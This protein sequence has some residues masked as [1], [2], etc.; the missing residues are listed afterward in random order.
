MCSPLDLF[1]RSQRK[2][3]MRQSFFIVLCACFLVPSTA[4]PVLA[5]NWGH[6]RGVNGNSVA[7][8]ANPPT[9]FGPSKNLKWKVAIPGRGSGSPVVWDQQVFAVTA[10]PGTKGNNSLQFQIHCYDRATGKPLWMKTAIEQVPPD[11]THPTNGYASASPCTDGKHVYAHFGSQGLYCYTMQGELVWER[12]FGTMR[13]RRSFGEGSSPTLVD[14]MI[15]V[16]WDHENGSKLFAVNNKTGELI[17]EVNRDEPTCWATPLIATD[18]SGRKQIVMNGQTAARGYDLKTGK[19]LWQCSGQTQR[20]CASAVA[21]QGIAYVASGFQ[22]SFVGAFDM[23]GAGNLKGTKS[24]KWTHDRNTPDVASPALSDNRL[25]YFKEKSGLLTCVDAASGKEHYSAARIDGVSNTYASP[26]VAGGYV[27]LT[28]RKGTIAVI[29]D[30]PKLEIVAKNSVDEGV[31]ATPAFADNDLF[32]RG[33]N[34]LF[35]FSKQP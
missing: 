3:P 27:F 5:D 30:S 16:P 7:A 23:S 29:K 34:T 6:W 13:T 35:C 32:V 24:V 1:V 8:N 25:Y 22:G 14:E 11:A 20:P 18:A 2:F 4:F 28:D 10:V 17:W 26:V 9:E 33:E 21:A 19:E 15:I 12:K 31:D